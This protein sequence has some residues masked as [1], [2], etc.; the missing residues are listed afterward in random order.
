MVNVILF[1]VEYVTKVFDLTDP[2]SVFEFIFQ[3]YNFISDAEAENRRLD[4]P[5]TRLLNA[6]ESVMQK[7]LPSLS[8]PKREPEDQQ[9]ST[10]RSKRNPGG[11]DSFDDL[12]VL[13]E[14]TNAGYTPTQPISEELT[15]LTPVSRNSRR[16]TRY[17]I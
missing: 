4:Q 16:W 17:L 15:P 6:Q 2:R 12:T 7:K 1:K 13:R 14:V 3:L 11:G 8:S 5:R 9:N 10:K